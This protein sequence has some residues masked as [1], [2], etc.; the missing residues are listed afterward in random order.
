[1]ADLII[2]A[3][4]LV[5]A[6]AAAGYIIKAKKNGVECIGCPSSGMCA[7]KHGKVSGCDCGGKD[8]CGRNADPKQ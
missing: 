4:L 8:S 7:H 2:A 3:I 5:I 1:M 6:G